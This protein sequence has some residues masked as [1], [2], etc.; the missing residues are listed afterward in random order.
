[1][2]LHSCKESVT[3]QLE[4]IPADA[5][6]VMVMENK[7]LSDK[8]GGLNEYGFI[9]KIRQAAFD[10]DA[11]LQSL[12]DRVIADPK[13][14]GIDTERTYLYA[15]GGDDP[16]KMYVSLVLKVQNAATFE[17]ALR[18]AFSEEV[19][20]IQDKGAYKLL[21]TDEQAAL[22]WNQQLLFLFA[23]NITELDYEECFAR[24]KGKSILS[25]ADFNEFGKH[26]YDIGFWASYGTFINMYQK[27]FNRLTGVFSVNELFTEL[28]ETYIH[29]YLNFDNGAVNL[30][31]VLTPKEK[32]EAF[33]KKFPLIKKD[34]NQKLLNDFPETSYLAFKMSVDLLEYVKL[35]KSM[36]PGF[37]AQSGDILD[38][39]D[40]NTVLNALNGDFLF[41]LYGFAQGPLPIPLLGLDFTVKSKDD[42]DRLVALIPKDAVK[43]QDDHYVIS[44]GP[45]PSIYFAY[46]DNRVFLTD[47][48]ESIETFLKSGH[49]KT[50]ASG[51]LGADLKKSLYLF[52][53]NMDVDSYPEKIRLMLQSGLGGDALKSLL[54]SLS[55]YKDFTA[56]TTDD[57]ESIITLRFKSRGN[58]LKQ[59]LE[60]IDDITA[61]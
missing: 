19:P 15:G 2:V 55:P 39:P 32:A 54:E 23:G 42:F 12:F 41:S 44:L 17:T 14:V 47:D 28:E 31:S 58:S 9:Q 30:S 51:E 60:S 18:E 27:A 35:I 11:S 24:P 25:V 48:A 10:E 21:Q 8:A 5:A 50:L 37:A 57:Y 4:A 46:K 52:Y 36:V 34:F 26:S 20:E 49:D 59:I 33:Y 38:D 45:V 40:T 3:P 1:M 7:Q 43:S 13:L 56:K 22:V 53:L 29:A 6:L 61:D 16:E